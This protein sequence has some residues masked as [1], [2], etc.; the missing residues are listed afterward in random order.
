ML[1]QIRRYSHFRDK[2][3]LIKT[4]S[5]NHHRLLNFDTTAGLSRLISNTPSDLWGRWTESGKASLPSA[6][7]HETA[8]A[9]AEIRHGMDAR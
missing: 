5:K 6:K 2:Q 8:I 9:L 7:A 1:H 3:L 4:Y